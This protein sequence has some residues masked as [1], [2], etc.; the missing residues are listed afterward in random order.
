MEVD[1]RPCATTKE[2][3]GAIAVI[4]EY[5]GLEGS[6]E[7]AERFL[8][9]L[10]LDRMHGAWDGER[11]VGGAGAFTFDV[12]VPGGNRVPCAG[13]C[14]IGVQPTDR[15][16]GVMRA[17]MRAQLDDIRRRGEPLAY[18][19]ASEGTIY[20]RFG[21]GLASQQASIALP[22]ERTA[23][24]QPFEPRG[25][26]RLVTQAQALEAFPPLHERVRDVRPG[27][28]SRS[29]AWW[30]TRRL[31]DDP[32]RRRPGLGPLQL[33]LLELDGE[34]AGYAMYRIAPG[35][36]NGI[37]TARV[38]VVEVI[39]PTPEA[40][41]ELWRFVLDIDWVASIEYGYLPPDSAL[42]LLLAHPRYLKQT[43]SDAVW[44]RLVDV[45]KALEARALAEGPS[46]VLEIED[47]FCPWNAGRWHVEA[48][49]VRRTDGEADLRL[50][51]AELGSVYLGG[52]TFGDLVRAVRATE[53][54]PGA[55]ARADRLFG[56]AARPWCP[57]IF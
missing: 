22:R 49:N 4:G 11:I 9:W 40:E 56:T 34:P 30:E 46:V 2:L 19:W 10:E 55:A 28:P 13:V 48:G 39:G 42:V 33:A 17:L 53:I 54:R 20:G 15:R 23:F 21:Y 52:F 24:A 14:V 31:A 32:R 35:I 41:R 16:R 3:A 12:S 51:A 1:V 8:N 37:T 43:L 26:V 57:E 5:F 18:L 7:N 47:A 36:E 27:M 38:V 25:T 29:R 6:I 44:V 50:D 45:G